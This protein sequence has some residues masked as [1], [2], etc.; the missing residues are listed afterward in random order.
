MASEEAASRWSWVARS[1]KEL[2]CRLTSAVARKSSTNT[3]TFVRS[4]SG[5][6]G[7]SR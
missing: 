2:A 7:V 4:T 6:T 3:D 5:T 1:R